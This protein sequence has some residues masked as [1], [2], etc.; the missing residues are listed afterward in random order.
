MCVFVCECARA[1]TCM[2]QAVSIHWHFTEREDKG[3]QEN[4]ISVTESIQDS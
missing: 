1:H 4:V 2:V 3:C